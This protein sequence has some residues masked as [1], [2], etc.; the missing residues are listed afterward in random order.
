MRWLSAGLAYVNF[1]AVAAVVFGMI[2]GGISRLLA[3]TALLCGF[4]AAIAAY[5]MTGDDRPAAPK[6]APEE[7]PR[8][9]KRKQRRVE[10]ERAAVTRA[11]P[12]VAQ[13]YGRLWLWL[14]VAVF[15]MFALRSY[16]WLLYI[17]GNELKIQSPNNLGDLGLHITYIKD[18]ANGTPLWPDNPIFVS[19]KLRYPAGIDILGG[20]LTCVGT[21]VIR[22][23]VWAGILGAAATCYALY[24]WAG[25]FGIAAFLF[26]GGVAGFQILKNWEFLDYQGD[27]TIAWKSLPLSMLVTQRGLPYAIPAGLLLLYHWRSKFFP[28]D[29]NGEAKRGVLPLWLE[30]SLYAAMPLFHVHTFLCLSIV[31]A[32]LF[33][34]GSRATKRETAI[35][36]LLA[37]IPATFFMWTVGDHFRAGS[38][39]KWAPGWVQNNGDFKM[40][41]FKFW[42]V[43]FGG[44]LPAVLALLGI[45][46]W[47]GWQEWQAGE[48]RFDESVVWLT[49]ATVMFLLTYLVKTAPWEWDNTKIL[50]WAYLI[51]L[52]FLWTNLIKKWPVVLR[53]AAC[54]IL[55]AS[56]FVTLIG[57]LKAGKEGFGFADRA[58]VDA[59]AVAVRK[60]PLDAR[61]ASYPT[62]NHPLLLQGRNVV[63]GYPGHL[64]TQGFDYSAVEPKLTAL[65]NGAPDW[66]QL[67]TQ[68]HARYLFWGR[69]EKQHYAQS[70]RPW[71][72]EL[73]P[74]LTGTWGSIYDLGSSVRAGQ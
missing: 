18:F 74:I 21:S 62:Y 24:R 16:C 65:L 2:G 20:L 61:F 8:L 10:R 28:A 23:L 52:P 63:M 70:R 57:G 64:W 72:R 30:A 42:L 11:R 5:W 9:S 49:A 34:F 32:C 6:S 17:D 39:L 37:F 69:E 31:L 47:R 7:E 4:A 44:W 51:V 26:N 68:L 27:K 22:G 13:R 1:A 56:G 19:G 50:I 46:G 29:Q 54:L 36:A 43:N 41:F 48:R 35:V 55:F 40:P 14:V 38:I 25:T 60:L 33:L 15:A 12:P 45:C 66:R 3:V 53:V 58:E 71:E 73:K 59:V 67:A